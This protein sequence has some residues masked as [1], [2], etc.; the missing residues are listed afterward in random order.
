[1][2]ANEVFGV[3]SYGLYQPVRW[4]RYAVNPAPAL[5]P[6]TNPAAV[7]GGPRVLPVLDSAEARPGQQFR[8]GEAGLY[9]LRVGGAA[10]CPCALWP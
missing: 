7:P 9:A 1:M 3:D 6:M 4:K 2:Q 5:P 10:A 8:F